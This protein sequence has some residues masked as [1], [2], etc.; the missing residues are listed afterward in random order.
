VPQ[1]GLDWEAQQS[2]GQ[3]F[4]YGDN[5]ERTAAGYPKRTPGRT[6]S[7]QGLSQQGLSQ[8]GLSQPGL[9]QQGFGEQGLGEQAPGIAAFGQHDLPRRET[10]GRHSGGSLDPADAPSQGTAPWEVP[11]EQPSAPDW[12]TALDQPSGDTWGQS[13]QPS[14]ERPGVPWEERAPDAG[15]RDFGHA[16]PAGQDF[17]GLDEFPGRPDFPAQQLR[18]P[19]GYQPNGR[20]RDDVAR[21]DPALQDFFAPKQPRQDDG[22]RQDNGR[23]E[24]GRFDGGRPPLSPPDR[25]EAN[26]SYLDERP[27]RD[28]SQLPAS[29]RPFEAPW[30]TTRRPPRNRETGASRAL[31]NTGASRAMRSTGASRALRNTGSARAL[32]ETGS[33]RVLRSAEE[34]GFS[35]RV[36]LTVGALLVLIIVVVVI[37]MNQHSGKS[38]PNAGPTFPNTIPS[39]TPRSPAPSVA[40]ATPSSSKTTKPGSG[41][42]KTAGYV[43]STPATAGGYPT[44]QDPHF[45]ATA[46]GT[47]QQVASAVAS[48]GGGTAHGSPV[49]AAYQLP[50]NGQVITFVGYQGTFTP[51]KIATILGSLG[52]DEN[53]YPAGPH[54]GTFGCVNTTASGAT[55]SGAVCVWATSTTLGITEFFS[56]TGPEALTASQEKG[57]ADTL[58]LRLSV[59][60][61][62]S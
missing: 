45:L 2:D 18:G 54:G 40:N 55:P 33:S 16:D 17:P 32:R 47:A 5:Q 1:A 53:T 44:G 11:V 48:G 34:L 29:E 58:K 43:L 10:R 12:G 27:R 50:T 28:P 25:R 42:L 57:A 38:T 52:T 35:R 39:S 26:G 46:T 9:G 31:R 4:G 60:A 56:S 22:L 24:P 61:K 41:T 30:D 7:Q 13:P 49:S 3:G 8:Q 23:Q 15:R 19:Q 20:E 37:L 51:A 59:E 14:R 36:Y 21:R 6:L 62:K